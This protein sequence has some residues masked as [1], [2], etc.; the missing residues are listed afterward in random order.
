MIKTINKEKIALSE[1]T[2]K[3]VNGT[4]KDCGNKCLI[5]NQQN[6]EAI[7]PALCEEICE[8]GG[9]NN[10][11]CPSGYTCKKPNIV[12]VIGYCES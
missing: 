7:C 8:C 12:N 5:I 4:W 2:C 11:Q 1:N 10:I 3:S 9:E 6:P